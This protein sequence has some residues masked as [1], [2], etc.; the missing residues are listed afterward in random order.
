MPKPKVSVS[1]TSAFFT[2]LDRD[3]TQPDRDHSVFPDSHIV[4]Q[5]NEQND[6]P[7]SSSCISYK[8]EGLNWML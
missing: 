4:L 2:T 3:G 5:L 8:L 7:P 1:Y 6:F